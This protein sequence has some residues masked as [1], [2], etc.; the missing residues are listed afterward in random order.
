MNYVDLPDLRHN[1]RGFG[2]RVDAARAI[3]HVEVAA[4]NGVSDTTAAESLRDFFVACANAA[5]KAAGGNGKRVK[6][7]K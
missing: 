1:V 2:L 6:V 7:N 3:S 5:D 4:M